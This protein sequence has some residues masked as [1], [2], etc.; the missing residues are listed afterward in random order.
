MRTTLRDR[1]GGRDGGGGTRGLLE[2]LDSGSRHEF[3]LTGDAKV[4]VMCTEGATDPGAYE[5]VVGS[6]A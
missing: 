5:R 1:L 3:C 4:L 2:L 6:L